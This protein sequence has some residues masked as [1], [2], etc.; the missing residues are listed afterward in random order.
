MPTSI[1]TIIPENGDFANTGIYTHICGYQG[2]IGIAARRTEAFKKRYVN[3]MHY[4]K[5]QPGP[6]PN[7][8]VQTPGF[9]ISTVS[10]TKLYAASVSSLRT[11]RYSLILS[12]Y[13]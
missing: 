11:Y 7:Y 10:E 4:H 5:K 9:H 8:P 1:L 12:I 3:I 6:V 13:I 2:F